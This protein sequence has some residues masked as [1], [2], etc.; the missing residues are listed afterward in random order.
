MNITITSHAKKRTLNWAGHMWLFLKLEE[1]ADLKRNRMVNVASAEHAADA[2]GIHE[3]I[4]PKPAPQISV[5][6]Y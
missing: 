2:N 3:T 6:K 5:I 4:T 1:K